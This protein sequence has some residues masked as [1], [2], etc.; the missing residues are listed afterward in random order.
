MK[1]LFTYLFIGLISS[2]SSVSLFKL[3]SSPNEKIEIE[4]KTVQPIVQTKSSINR[5]TGVDLTVAAEKS[6]SAVVHIKSTAI[7]KHTH[8]R[9]H[10][11]FR[12]FFGDDFFNPRYHYEQSRPE[13]KI[14]TGSGVI[15]N[16]DGYIVTNFHVIQGADDIEISMNDN[17]NFKAKIIGTDPSTDLAVLKIDEGDLPF[18]SF[19]NSDDVKV[20]EWVLA[21]GNP[22][23]L[24]S[25]V[26]AGIVSA[27]A[28]NINIIKGQSAIESFIQT[29]AAVN[30]GN[31]GGALVNLKGD[32]VGINTAIASPTGTYSGYSFAVPSNI[33]SKIVED[34]IE[35]G[36]IQ[37]AYLGV[38][39]R[40]VDN[41][42]S[43]EK[44]LDVKQGV[45]IYE[46][47]DG[48]SASLG[49]IK[50]GDVILNIN[51]KKTLT[52][53]KLQEI[54]SS[55]R[56]G[57]KIKVN[58]LRDGRQKD[59]QLTLRTKDG[60]DKIASKEKASVLDKLGIELK[61]SKKGLIIEKILAGKIQ[62][63]TNIKEGFIIQKI[64]KSTI[65]TKEDL[66][67][68]LKD[69]KGGILIEGKYDSLPDTYY[70]ALGM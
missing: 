27:K 28:R 48:S 15:V 32:L 13:V 1:K 40:N 22:F 31:S 8:Q 59:I 11:P 53:P 55:F 54:V 42:L 49:G 4:H 35:F 47:V 20:G 24:N 68:V 19:Q 25:T 17:R 26:T 33:V 12:D 51:D 57:D 39:I 46:V 64:G 43:K 69:K 36:S 18:L 10:N 23:N 2:L 65:Q 9:Q 41:H 58:I 16:K 7:R 6:M 3:F 44:G 29:D 63:E 45:Y 50:E 21:V 70:Y 60:K 67:K 66:V 14:G 52:V 38:V 37:R 61:E 34:L 5:S 62:K 56:P 30:P